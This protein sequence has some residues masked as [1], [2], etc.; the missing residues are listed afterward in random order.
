MA[1]AVICILFVLCLSSCAT[2]TQTGTLVGGAT[3]AGLGALIGAIVAGET[4][5]TIGAGVGALI[6]SVIGGVVGHY[7]DQQVG[8]R[9]AAAQEIGLLPKRGVLIKA[10]DAGVVPH[11]ARAGETVRSHVKYA[12][13]S[14]REGNDVH[15]TEWRAVIKDGELIMG[16]VVR[17]LTRPQGLHV[18]TYQFRLPPET[19]PGEYIMITALGRERPETTALSLL[20]VK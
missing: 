18:S 9:R 10:Q 1:K 5:A 16:P 19:P 12:L 15:F 17:Q 14:A 4:G 8:D 20:V 13:L 2:R 3:G 7:Q 11:P 6:G